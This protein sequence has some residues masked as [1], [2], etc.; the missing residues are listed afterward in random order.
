MQNIFDDFTAFIY[1]L[2]DP[3][4]LG[5]LAEIIAA[6]PLLILI[7]IFYLIVMRTIILSFRK[8][9]MSKEASSGIKLMV[10][11]LFLAVAASVILS[12]TTVI[13]GTALVTGGALFGTAIG[14][15]FSKALSNI[16]SGFYVLGARPFRVGDYIK[17]GD[18]E[19]IVMEITLNYTRLLLPDYTR[20]YVP[21]SKVIDSQLTNY[22]RRI[23]DLM[24]ERG[25]EFKG[26]Q[27]SGSMVKAALDGFR[28]LTKGT[29]VFRYSFEIGVHKDF[30]IESADAYFDQICEK[31]KDEFI[32]KPEVLFWS[33]NMYGLIYRIAY[34][35][36][37]PMDILGKGSDFAHEISRFQHALKVT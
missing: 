18:I 36:T 16:V 2:L 37:D 9:G 7:Y 19:G 15:A 4:Q 29:E 24:E 34:M 26:N 31:W 3:F 28:S 23:D 11:I 30:I 33:E 35:V 12:A 14:L 8:A 6:I 5:A 32:E 27:E 22:R 13:S 25:R 17:I 10:R 21:N 20:E 1:A